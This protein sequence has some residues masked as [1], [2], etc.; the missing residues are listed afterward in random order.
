MFVHSVMYIRLLVRCVCSVGVLFFVLRGGIV[1]AEQIDRYDVSL[2]IGDHGSVRVQ[3]FIVMDF[4]DEERHG[5]VRSIPLRYVR[6]DDAYDIRVSHVSVTDGSGNARSYAVSRDSDRF[7]I[8]V[9]SDNVVVSGMQSYVFSYAV[10]GVIDYGDTSDE[11]LWN[12]VP[13]DWNVPVHGVRARIGL[14]EPIARIYLNAQCVAGAYG[15]IDACDELKA[16][17]RKDGTTQHVLITHAALSAGEGVTVSVRVPKG[18]ISQPRPLSNALRMAY[19][20]RY[21]IV[22]GLFLCVL[23]MAVIRSRARRAV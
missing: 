18:L 21:W 3:E 7:D 20:Q 23:M 8:R 15:S 13:H 11:F 16:D 12:I 10:D 17:D 5:I 19:D 1:F 9:G 2:E 4:G 22:G 14:P 6:G